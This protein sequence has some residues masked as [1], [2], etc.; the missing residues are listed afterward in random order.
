MQLHKVLSIGILAVGGLVVANVTTDVSG[1]P[2][3]SSALGQLVDGT[4]WYPHT[5]EWAAIWFT[6]DPG[7]VPP[8]FDLLTTDDFTPAFPGGPPRP[9][10]CTSTVGGF[11]IW[12][13]GPPPLDFLPLEAH[14]HGLGA[15]PVWFVRL[16]EIQAA[17]AD[18]KLTITELLAMP[19]LRKGL[20]SQFELVQLFGL[21]RPQ[22]FGNGSIEVTANG[23]LQDGTPFQVEDVEMGKKDGGGVNFTRHV[24]IEFQ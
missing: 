15:V 16:S 20:A 10:L 9:F 8:D 1:D 17:T 21:L 4:P 5:D 2:A 12:K 11:A 18:N 13:N 24:R 7:C 22:G 23:V 6:R 19:S 3:Y 14:E